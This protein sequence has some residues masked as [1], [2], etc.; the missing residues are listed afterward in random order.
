MSNKFLD[1]EKGQILTQD[2]RAN[3]VNN[4]Y[5]VISCFH[6]EMRRGGEQAFYWGKRMAELMSPLVLQ[7]YIHSIVFEETRDHTLWEVTSH[8]DS[9]L[10]TAYKW[11]GRFLATPKY[12]EIDKYIINYLDVELPTDQTIEEIDDDMK[13]FEKYLN[14]MHKDLYDAYVTISFASD[15]GKLWKRVNEKL[16]EKDMITDPKID[17]MIM[18]SKYS[19]SMK[20]YQALTTII[21]RYFKVYS[22]K[23]VEAKKSVHKPKF[24]D[25]PLLPPKYAF[26]SHTLKARD[27]E[28]VIKKYGWERHEEFGYDL[29]WA[30]DGLPCLWRMLAHLQYGKKYKEKKWNDVKITRKYIAQ[31]EYYKS[32]E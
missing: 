32:E 30:G 26:D 28:K 24:G 21:E 22:M 19:D 9:K 6:K 20:H 17:K 1:Y 12:W 15:H 7:N 8:K 4:R 18:E 5:T 25:I 10:E 27:I 11:I 23:D 29:R 16:I 14:N 13:E 3:L 31:W 2:S